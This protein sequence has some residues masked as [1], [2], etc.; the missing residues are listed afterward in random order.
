MGLALIQ[1]ALQDE[2]IVV[3]VGDLT[4][5]DTQIRDVLKVKYPEQE[6]YKDIDLEK[7]KEILEPLIKKSLRVNAA[8]K[9]GLENDAKFKRA[10]DDQKMRIM[11]SKYYEKEI[12]DKLVSETE[13]E[14]VLI[15]KGVELKASHILIGFKGTRSKS[16]RTRDDAE[17]L[18]TDILKELEAGADFSTTAQKYSDD[19]SAK[20]NNGELG[21]FTWGRMVGPF[22][23]AAWDLKIGEI[24][25][26]VETMFGFH[27]IKLDDRRELPNYKPDRTQ[28]N[29]N[30]LKQTLL[31]AQGDAARN[32]WITHYDGLKEKYDYVLYEDSIRF[33]S[34]LIDEKIK[35]ERIL[36]G[37]FTSQQKEITLAE[38]DGDSFKF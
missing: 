12:V 29:I 22:Q 23:E 10:L 21:Y 33:A 26:P 19:P 36:P 9:L 16:D 5:T 15:R 7:K 37:T 30:L 14:K 2:D 3:T 20:T 24:S 4:I 38:Y 34:K 1:C 13:V 31:K 28:R 18:V 25:D 8:Y 32:Y 17:K 6:N 27:I 35:A 11:G